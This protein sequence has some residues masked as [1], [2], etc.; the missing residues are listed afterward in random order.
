MIHRILSQIM[1]WMNYWIESWTNDC[2]T[3]D[4]YYDSTLQNP[5]LLFDVFPHIDTEV[6]FLK[7]FF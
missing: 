6:Q 5:L 1:I 4:T 2:D 3:N 7:S